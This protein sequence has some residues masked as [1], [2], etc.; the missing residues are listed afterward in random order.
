MIAVSRLARDAEVVDAS[1]TVTPYRYDNIFV[2]GYTTLQSVADA[3]DANAELIF[4]LNPHL[5]QGMT[6]PGEM[7]PVRVPVGSGGAAVARL[8]GEPPSRRTDD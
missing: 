7:Y 4:A 3:L 6:P 5:T 2:P 8:S 1:G